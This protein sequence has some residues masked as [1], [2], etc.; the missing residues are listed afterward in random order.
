[1]ISDI[2]EGLRNPERGAADYEPV[3]PIRHN[4]AL[5]MA[6]HT[7]IPVGQS[8]T[9]EEMESLV[10]DLFHC[11]MPSLTPTGKPVLTILTA[12]EIRE[13]IKN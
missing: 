4:A 5:S 10:G 1:M 9:P 13:R 12:E 8:L 11:Q 7:A 6:R 2:Q 3:N